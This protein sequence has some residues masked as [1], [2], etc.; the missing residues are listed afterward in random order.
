VQDRTGHC[1][2]N[3]LLVEPSR[4]KK[5]KPTEIPG[6]ALGEFVRHAKRIVPNALLAVSHAT[7]C[8]RGMD[9]NF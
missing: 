7:L 5:G 1:Q 2:E 9:S 3:G 4:A 6:I 8:W